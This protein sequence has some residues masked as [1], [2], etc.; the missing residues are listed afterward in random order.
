LQANKIEKL[1]VVNAYGKLVGLITYKDIQKVKNFPNACKDEYGRL[2]VGA[3]VGVAADNID[4]VT[5]L[6]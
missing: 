2:R 3:A 4:R 6:V 5:A 1:P